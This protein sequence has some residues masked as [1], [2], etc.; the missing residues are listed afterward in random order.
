M[1]ISGK[2]SVLIAI[3]VLLGAGW[4]LTIPLAKFAVSEGYRAFGLIFWQLVIGAVVLRVLLL[5]LGRDLPLGR[6]QIKLYL[7]IACIGTILPNAASYQAA[8]YLPGGILAICI[9]LVPMFAFPIAL[10]MGNDRF[11]WQKCAGLFAGLIGVLILT[12]PEASLPEPW[13]VWIVPLALIAPMFY[14]FEGNWITRVGTA[15]LDPVQLLCGA[16]AV[17]TVLAL[18]LALITGQ[19]IDPRPPH[20]LPDAALIASSV[21]HALVY[22]GYVWLVGLAGPVFTAQVSYLVTGFGVLWAMILL[23][24]TYSGWVWLAMAVIFAGLFLVRPRVQ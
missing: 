4:G 2:Q 19:W 16:S 9:A 12:L 13:M 24:E 6:D 18:P 8:I 1:S 21:I 7:V 15:G 5:I 20:G 22:S 14:G 3:L 11:D 23:N 17:G 10:A